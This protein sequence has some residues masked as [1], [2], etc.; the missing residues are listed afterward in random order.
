MM[1]VQIHL[2]DINLCIILQVAKYLCI[3]IQVVKYM[4]NSTGSQIYVH[5]V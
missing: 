2:F 1:G 4:Y 5:C 3:F